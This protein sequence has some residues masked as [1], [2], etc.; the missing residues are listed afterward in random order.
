[1]ASPES[2]LLLDTHVL[3]WAAT[4]DPRLERIDIALLRDPARDLC[5]NAVVA[6]ELADLQSRGRIALSE[7]IEFLQQHMDLRLIDFPTACW[8]IAATLPPIHGD[9]IDRMLIAHALHA[10]MTLVTADPIIRRYPVACA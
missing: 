5:V 1:M 4:G 6:F 3:V 9:P 2:P 7:P 10:G 8:Q